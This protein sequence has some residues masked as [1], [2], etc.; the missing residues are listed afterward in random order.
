[1][2]LPLLW[3][4]PFPVSLSFFSSSRLSL[5]FPWLYHPL[6]TP[7]L[8][9]SFLSHASESPYMPFFFN[10]ASTSLSLLH[11]ANTFPSPSLV[12]SLISLCFWFSHFPLLFSYYLCLFTFHSF[13]S[14]TFPLTLYSF[15]LLS[16]S[17][18]SFKTPFFLYKSS[19]S[20]SLPLTFKPSFLLPLFIFPFYHALWVASFN[21]FISSS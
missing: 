6:L 9:L 2:T 14:R 16:M 13:M 18:L 12:P 11:L 10:P 17:F 15:L 20:L 3:H 4:S 1:M 5:S 19:L 8:R 7:R 21:T